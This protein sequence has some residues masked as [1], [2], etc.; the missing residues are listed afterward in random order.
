MLLQSVLPLWGRQLEPMPS[1]LFMALTG[2][3]A[4]VLHPAMCHSW[5]EQHVANANFAFAASVLVCGWQVCL[6][7]LAS[8]SC[9]L[10]LLA[11]SGG[12]QQR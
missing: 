12:V 11:S 8:V 6:H 5:L 2:L 9:Q 4:C 3:A 7:S 1:K 10:N